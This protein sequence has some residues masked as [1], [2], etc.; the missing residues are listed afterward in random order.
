MSKE[1]S[2]KRSEGRIGNRWIGVDLDGTLAQWDGWKGHDYIGAPIPA[3]LDR[4]KRWIKMDIEVR[5]FTARASVPEHIEPVEK[6][7]KDNGLAGLRVTNEKDYRMLQLWDD[8]C[9]QV[10]PNTG[11]LI[12]NATWV[13]PAKE[14]EVTID[15]DSTKTDDATST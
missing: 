5:I 8:R 2:R 6:W 15:D 12:K 4:V 14:P 3:M 10:I 1:R 11:E 9:V 7:L 13:E